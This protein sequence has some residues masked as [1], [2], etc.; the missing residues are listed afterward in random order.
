MVVF[1]DPHV[2]EFLVFYSYFKNNFKSYCLFSFFHFWL[3]FYKG[4]KEDLSLHALF[5]K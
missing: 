1:T 2:S 5:I 3:L 4:R